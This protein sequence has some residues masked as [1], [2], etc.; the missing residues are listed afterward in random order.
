M[1]RQF[2]FGF[3]RLI[4][5][6]KLSPRRAGQLVYQYRTEKEFRQKDIREKCEPLYRRN[7]EQARFARSHCVTSPFNHGYQKSA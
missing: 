7:D 6:D 1:A 5:R 3:N 2:T 4:P